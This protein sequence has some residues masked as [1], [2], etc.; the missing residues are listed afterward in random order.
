[1]LVGERAKRVFVVTESILVSPVTL[2]QLREPDPTTG[3]PPVPAPVV[4]RWETTTTRSPLGSLVHA[5]AVSPQ[6]ITRRPDE[7]FEQFW[8]RVRVQFGPNGIWQFSDPVVVDDSA[9]IHGIRLAGPKDGEG[10]VVTL[11]RNNECWEG[12]RKVVVWMS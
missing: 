11:R 7:N 8:D 9:Y 1:M 5:N 4:E 2:A 6:E 10:V 12:V 3:K